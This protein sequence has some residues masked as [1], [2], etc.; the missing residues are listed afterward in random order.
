[1]VVQHEEKIHLQISNVKACIVNS[2]SF[3]FVYRLWSTCAADSL[4]LV[5]LAS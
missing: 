1:M 5:A 4:H 2:S 3:Y